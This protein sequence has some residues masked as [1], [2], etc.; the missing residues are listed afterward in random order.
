MFKLS[1]RDV[2]HGVDTIMVIDTKDVPQGCVGWLS[3]FTE[4]VPEGESFLLSRQSANQLYAHLQK[5][6]G[7]ESDR[8][9]R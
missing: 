7:K 3:L 9:L 2:M 6:L 1:D 4:A 8:R 5:I